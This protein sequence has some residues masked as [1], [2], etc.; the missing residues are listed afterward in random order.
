M[1]NIGVAVLGTGWV[2]GEHVKSFRKIPDCRV[3]GL[4]SRTTEGAQAKAR[5][6]G[7]DDVR[8][9]PTYEEMLFISK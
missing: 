4:C 9:Y 6:L 2:A 8:I 1:S 5:E 7:A 3:V